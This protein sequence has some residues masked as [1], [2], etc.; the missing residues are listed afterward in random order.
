M[1]VMTLEQAK[2][3]QVT[4]ANNIRYLAKKKGVGIAKVEKAAGVGIGYLS[5]ISAKQVESLSLV[6]FL[7]ASEVL[8]VSLYDL[9][10]DDLIKELESA[11]I[12]SQIAE[13]DQKKK[14]LEE[15]YERIWGK[16]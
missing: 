8:D 10:N 6:C 14:E 2:E 1:S 4:I 15:K 5:R 13:L 3:K 9:I 11:E 7:I 12:A 16:A